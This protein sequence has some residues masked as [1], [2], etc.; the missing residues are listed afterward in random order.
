M[1][2]NM[3]ISIK[4]KL[5]FSIVSI[6]LTFGIL[7]TISVFNYSKYI[8]VEYEKEHLQEITV[9]KTYQINAIFNF[10]TLLVKKIAEQE[11]VINYVLEPDPEQVENINKILEGYNIGD[12]FSAIYLINEEG[13]TLA[14][15]D[16]TFIGENY[17]FRDYFKK[18]IKGDSCADVSLGVTSK[19]LGYYFSTPI[20]NND[21]GV[22]GVAVIKMKPTVVDNAVNIGIDISGITL[23]D[24]FGIVISSSK[25]GRLYKSLGILNEETIKEIE[26]LRRYQNIEITSLGYE[27]VQNSLNFTEN[28]RLFEFYDATEEEKEEEI[29]SLAKLQDF[30]FYV[31]L[32]EHG[33]KYVKSAKKIAY[34]LSIFIAL[35]VLLASGIIVLMVLRLIEPINKLKKAAKEISKGHLNQKIEATSSDE[36]GQ[37]A[38]AF[39]TMSTQ[40]AE[41]KKDIDI[42]V[43]Q[44]TRD[45]QKF[46]LAVENASDHIIITDPEGIVIFA[47]KAVEEITGYEKKE[48]LGKK[49]GT[50]ENWGGGMGEKFYKKLWKTIKTDKSIFKGEI[51]NIRKGGAEYIAEASITPILDK[52]GEVILFLAI[53]R[54]ITKVKEVDKMRSDFISMASHQL[55]TPLSGMKWISEMLLAGDAGELNDKQKEFMGD[56]WTSNERMINLVN[57]LLKVSRIETGKKIMSPEFVDPMDVVEEALADLK[58][59]IYDKKIKIK[60]EAGKNLSKI[61][62]DPE[63]IKE[64]YINL[65]N[66]AIAYGKKGSE[67]KIIITEKDGKIVSAIS[68]TGPGVPK[69]EQSKIFSKF[70]RGRN[71]IK[72]NPEGSGLGLYLA[73]EIIR[74]S[75]GKMWLESEQDKGATFW[76][77]LPVKK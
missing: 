75:G 11:A 24:K 66:N 51:T 5:L 8:I 50:K 25:A 15:T 12:G 29:L 44:Q 42:K 10:S 76:F 73:K 33:A 37:L 21:K 70:F 17:G 36:L 49:A 13:T 46:K 48:I 57:T 6:I 39:N 38:E 43:D 65:L 2:T 31:L 60:V 67:I 56:I 58:L 9:Q 40:L 47:N 71:I 22:I 3:K 69:D 62:V 26:E 74:S 4:T 72:M 1:K 54:D 28:P 77:S 55:R 68:D 18:G 45:L 59:K 53:E 52:K 63:L 34:I 35:S 30:P 61:N 32:E 7:A 41:S 20:L 19:K 27:I 16:E 14:S 23:V 64:V